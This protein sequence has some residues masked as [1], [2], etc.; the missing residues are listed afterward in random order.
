[1]SEESAGTVAADVRR[2]IRFENLLD[3]PPPHVAGYNF[4]TRFML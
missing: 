1:M 2:R 3:S 4:K